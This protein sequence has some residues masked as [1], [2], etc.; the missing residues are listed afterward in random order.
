MIENYVNATAFTTMVKINLEYNFWS[1]TGNVFACIIFPIYLVNLATWSYKGEMDSLAKE[2]ADK[3]DSTVKYK[4][5]Y[6]IGQK[7]DHMVAEAEKKN[8]FVE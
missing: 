4:L 1:R 3:F 5:I 2:T 7:Y 6:A 8:N